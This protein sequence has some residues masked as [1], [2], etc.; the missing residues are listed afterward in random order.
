MGAKFGTFILKT[1][2]TAAA[3]WVLA[4]HQSWACSY[5]P[6]D[7]LFHEK[8][9]CETRQDRTWDC[10]QNRCKATQEILQTEKAFSECDEIED[11]EQ[12]NKCRLE[13]AKEEVEDKKGVDLD[14]NQ[15]ET[16]TA[17]ECRYKLWWELTTCLQDIP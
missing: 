14:K 15:L 11:V 6:E 1:V 4:H 8:K 17:L 3:I 9:E 13:T 2:L 7:P 10:N 12:A 5:P 16:K